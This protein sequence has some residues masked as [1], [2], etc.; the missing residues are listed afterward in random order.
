MIFKNK[1][2]V[3]A[4]FIILFCLNVLAWQAVYQLNQAGFLEVIFLDVGQ[5]DATLIKTPQN[6]YILIDGGQGPEILEK[7]AEHIPFWQK[8]IDLMI[9]THAHDDHFGGLI[10]VLERYDVE[11]ILW[12]GSVGQSASFKVWHDL[13]LSSQ[14]EVK[15]ARAGQ[16]IKS[17]NFSIDIL[18]PF[19]SLEGIKFKDANLASIVTRVVFEDTSFLLTG[20]AYQINEKE[21]IE[22]EKIC[23]ENDNNALCRVMIL[24]SDLLKVGH[25]GSKTSTAEEFVQAVSPYLAVIS[26]GKDNR[27]GHPHQDTLDTLE[28]YDITILR[29]DLD[30]DIR[31][32]SDGQDLIISNF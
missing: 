8:N 17:N 15:I 7:I 1:K 26:A 25:H 12:N 21:L 3:A 28:K 20:D 9:L 31:I 5:G 22:K 19:V 10:Y 32:I 16:K 13:V 23:K 30:G 18:Y 29:T 6:H 14:A 2:L 4:F 24:D 27:Y 11:H